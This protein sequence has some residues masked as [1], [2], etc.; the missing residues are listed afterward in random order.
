MHVRLPDSRMF[1]GQRFVGR[2]FRTHDRGI[3]V[4][5]KK[6][7]ILIGWRGGAI[8]RPPWGNNPLNPM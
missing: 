8:P 3:I 7:R 2:P 1:R 4:E 6:L 5:I